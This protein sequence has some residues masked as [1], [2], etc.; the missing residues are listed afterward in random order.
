MDKSG[1]CF[2]ATSQKAVTKLFANMVGLPLLYLW[3]DKRRESEVAW[4]ETLGMG[5][6]LTPSCILFLHL[7]VNKTLN[8]SVQHLTK[9][10]KG[11]EGALCEF[12]V[13][14]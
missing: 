11:E 10:S 14:L 12:R 1:K 9:K 7:S 3:R 4:R 8:Y 6:I 13:I 2:F 5:D